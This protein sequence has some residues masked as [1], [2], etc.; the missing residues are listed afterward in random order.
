MALAFL[1]DTRFDL[2]DHQQAQMLYD[3]SIALLR[4]L[5]TKNIL[6]YS[7]RRSGYL[8]LHEGLYSKAKSSFKESLGLDEET[9]HQLGVTACVAGLAGVIAGEGETIRALELF[10]AVDSSLNA[11]E[12]SLF[13]PD[14]IE[15][16]RN[17]A[18]VRAQLDEATRS[19]AWARGQAMTLDQAVDY[20]VE[21]VGK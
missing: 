14:E 16:T 17:S 19:A 2:G 8:A 7:L 9:G 4:E 11:I 10:G 12:S 15:Y 6:A 21:K 5:Q 3:E 18:A 1:G 20:A 13:S